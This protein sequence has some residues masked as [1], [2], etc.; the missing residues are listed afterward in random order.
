MR[1]PP[2]LVELLHLW[3]TEG[4]PDLATAPT[5]PLCTEDLAAQERDAGALFVVNHSGG[6]DSQAM[7]IRLL[8]WVPR[9]QLV[10]VHATLGDVEWPGALE[11]AQEQAQNAGVAFRVAQANKTLLGM[12]ENRYRTDPTV[13]S[14]PSAQY[15]QCTSDL[16]RGPIAKEIRAHCVQHGFTRVVSCVGIRAQ[17][18]PRRAKLQVWQ[19][20]S[21]NST[22]T[23][24]WFNWLPIH[25]HTVHDVALALVR[26]GQEPH[27]A[28]LLGNERL[29]CV[30]CILS[31]ANDL[32]LGA[33]YNPDLY[34]Q[35]LELE[36]KT[37]YTAHESRKAL[38]EIT[39]LTASQAQQAHA[40][41]LAQPP[42][43]LTE[44]ESTNDASR[45]LPPAL[46]TELRTQP[47]ENHDYGDHVHD[48]ELC[49]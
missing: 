16:K 30:F 4:I 22:R 10:V 9:E 44:G 47:L 29:S 31:S 27:P 1:R 49:W 14:W 15:R 12:V 28:Y 23:R 41:L 40:A 11:Q 19:H 42:R 18:S 21:K 32:R 43:D 6:K 36:K 25:T 20:V 8:D 13:P 35:Y 5:P 24:N 39:G 48:S 3:R 33:L 34:E 46:S 38:H 17:E 7:M 2:K 26:A 45:C 37:G